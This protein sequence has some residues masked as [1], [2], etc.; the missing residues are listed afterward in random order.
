MGVVVV[1]ASEHA[2]ARHEP[3]VRDLGGSWEAEERPRMGQG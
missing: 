3:A 1:H 2:R